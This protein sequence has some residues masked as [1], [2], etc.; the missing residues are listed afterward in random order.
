MQ[1]H[2]VAFG[3]HDIELEEG[4]TMVQAVLCAENSVTESLRD[5]ALQGSPR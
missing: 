2:S 3:V 1:V 4:Q 5:R